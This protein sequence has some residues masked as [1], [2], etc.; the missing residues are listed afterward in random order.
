MK[1][2]G[3]Q[4][5]AARE[6]SGITQDELARALGLDGNT[7]SRFE[8]GLSEPHRSN[9]AKIQAEL[10]RRG[11]EFTNGDSPPRAGDGIGVRLNY[12]TAA[13]FAKT[14]KGTHQ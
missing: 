6:L 4:V 12:A 8:S 9:L 14:A 3:K 7:I 5:A 2:S 11:I 13:E 1:I 10:E